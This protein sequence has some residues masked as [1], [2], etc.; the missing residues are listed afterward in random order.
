[1]NPRDFCKIARQLA[2]GN[3]PAQLRT[4]ASRAYY[5]VFNVGVELIGPIVPINRGPGGHG[6]IVRLLQACSDLD[7]R[8]AGSGLGT[9]HSRRIDADYEMGNRSVENQKTIAA[10]VVT[11]EELIDR[12]DTALAGTN[13]QAVMKSIQD[14]WINIERGQLQGRPRVP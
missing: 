7:I 1:M 10:S 6:Q 5:A 8:A 12:L 3:D 2:G 14:F 9:L 11:A 13:S 4:A